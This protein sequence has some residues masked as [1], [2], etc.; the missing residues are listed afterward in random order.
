MGSSVSQGLTDHM[1]RRQALSAF[2]VKG[3]DLI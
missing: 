2:S 1:T 3:V